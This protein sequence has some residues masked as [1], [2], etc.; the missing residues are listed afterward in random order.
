MGN[1]II[2][3]DRREK[4]VNSISLEY[5]EVVLNLQIDREVYNWRSD[6]SIFEPI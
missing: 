1:A 4:G 5:F 2:T 3:F 6:R